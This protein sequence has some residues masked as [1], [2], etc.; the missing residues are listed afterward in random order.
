MER[1]LLL[2]RNERR[3]KPGDSRLVAS[4]VSNI[5][6]ASKVSVRVGSSHVEVSIASGTMDPSKLGRLEELIGKLIEEKTPGSEPE[7]T[8]S[9]ALSKYRR[10]MESERF[11]EAHE[12]LESVWREGRDSGLQALILYAAALAKAQEGLL[13]GALRI[14]ERIRAIGEAETVRIDCA[15]R[16]VL[17]ILEGERVDPIKCLNMPL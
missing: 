15:R 5:M 17:R 2:F 14:L 11:W 16:Q 8:V 4:I 9:G 6:G 10:Y 13:E 3:L 1:R 7:A 12:I